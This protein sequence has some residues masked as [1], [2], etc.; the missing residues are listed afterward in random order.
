MVFKL[1]YAIEFQW[2]RRTHDL[3]HDYRFIYF[4]FPIVFS[5]TYKW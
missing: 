1:S 2:I 3:I 4:Q 5:K